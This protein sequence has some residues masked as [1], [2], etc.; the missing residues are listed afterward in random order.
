MTAESEVFR[1]ARRHLSRRDPVLRR[2]IAAVGACSLRYEPDRFAA[3]VRSIISQQ[4]STRAA[5]S[6]R[7]RLEQAAA[8]TGLTPAGLLALSDEALREA[9]LSAAKARSLRDLAD[10]VHSGA[11]PLDELHEKEDEE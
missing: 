4:S 6:I 9:G 5:A 10:K 7:G 1:K 3:L 11:V 8:A 2:L